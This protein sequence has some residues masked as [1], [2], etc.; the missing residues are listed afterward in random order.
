MTFICVT[1][2]KHISTDQ[3]KTA[4]QFSLNATYSNA[5]TTSIKE[6]YVTSSGAM[7]KQCHV[8]KQTRRFQF[9]FTIKC[10]DKEEI[11][12]DLFA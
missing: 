5:P 9:S 6:C 3:I 12:Y 8:N 10:I 2:I 7:L 1:K 11:S 4:F